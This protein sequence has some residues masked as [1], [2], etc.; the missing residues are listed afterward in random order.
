MEIKSKEF[1]VFYASKCRARHFHRRAKGK[2]IEFCV[3]LEIKYK[4]EWAVF[5]RYDSSHEFAHRDVI[6]ANGRKEKFTLGILDYNEALTFAQID[7][8]KNWQTYQ[9]NFFKEVGYYEKE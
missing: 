4:G 9:Q 3:Q 8:D 5:I 2:V 6:H 7:L 1:I